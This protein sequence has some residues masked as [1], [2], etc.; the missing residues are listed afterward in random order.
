MSTE[1]TAWHPPFVTLIDERRPRWVQ[2]G[3]GL[4]IATELR[5]D[6]LLQVI[7]DIARD[8]AQ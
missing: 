7:A 8:E 5:V 1:L 3:G 4:R 6:G 2:V